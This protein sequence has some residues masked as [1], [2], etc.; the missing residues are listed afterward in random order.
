[1]Q[2][3]R[4]GVRYGGDD[5]E[6]VVLHRQLRDRGFDRQFL[7]PSQIVLYSLER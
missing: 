1:M 5:C 6:H 3:L 7:N 2:A 4:S